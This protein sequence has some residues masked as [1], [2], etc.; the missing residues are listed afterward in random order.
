M[1]FHQCLQALARPFGCGYPVHRG[2][3][4]SDDQAPNSVVSDSPIRRRCTP[5]LFPAILGLHL[6]ARWPQQKLGKFAPKLV[7]SAHSSAGT[8]RGCVCSAVCTMTVGYEH[9]RFIRSEPCVW[10]FPDHMR[11]ALHPFRTFR[12]LL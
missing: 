1:A 12:H 7:L 11:A 10:K 6:A 4:S 8:R 9:L 3:P 2:A 5:T